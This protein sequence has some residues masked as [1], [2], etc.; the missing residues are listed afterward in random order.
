MSL[1]VEEQDIAGAQAYRLTGLAVPTDAP[2]MLDEM[3]E[4][5]V[6]HATVEREGN[7][8]FMTSALGT[9]AFALVDGRIRIEIAAPTSQSLQLS[10]N[11]IA[12]HMF[13]FAG[14][15]PL[16]LSWSVSAEAKPLPNFREATVVRAED[17]TPH[18]RRVILRCEDV[19][20]FIGAGMHVRLLLPPEG[21]TPVWPTMGEDGR[22]DW[23]TGDNELAVRVYTIRFVDTE[24]HE[25]WIDF[26]QHPMPDV[27]TPG[28]DFA[29]DARPG[30]L[31]GMLGPGG[32]NMPAAKSMILAGDES[33][34][35][36][37]A[38]IVK[39]APRGTCM[40]VMVEV[41]DEREEQPMPTEGEIEIRWLHRRTYS[42]LERSPLVQSTLAAIEASGPETFVWVACEKDDLRIVRNALKARGH[43]RKRM[44]AAWYWE[45]AKA[46]V[47]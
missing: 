3:C 1:V 43:D 18:M 44:Y 7:K 14:E 13:Y 17:V 30:Q 45:R 5:F 15:T 46:S 42:P 19:S 24:R 21:R 32:G 47:G 11:S 2:W 6:E 22:L 29:R 26:L 37:I 35:P 34:L 9:A 20:P 16:E 39:E 28:A 27:P 23:P 8:A 12:E 36:A 10:Q 40:Q 4:H 33:A 31:I 25:L 41:E 38:R